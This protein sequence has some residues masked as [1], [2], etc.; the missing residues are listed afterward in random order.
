MD[1]WI[2][3]VRDSFRG[4]VEGVRQAYKHLAVRTAV[5]AYRDYDD[6]DPL[7]I[8]DFTPEQ[9]K[10]TLFLAKCDTLSA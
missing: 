2:N 1:S 5:V 8:L 3:K 6:M 7:E 10:F 9:S 4:L